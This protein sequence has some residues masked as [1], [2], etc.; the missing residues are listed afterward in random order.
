M[1]RITIV[2]IAEIV[3]NKY[4]GFISLDPQAFIVNLRFFQVSS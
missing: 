1:D 4:K 2:F 3:E